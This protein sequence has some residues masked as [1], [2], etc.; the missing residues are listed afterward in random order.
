M[1]GAPEYAFSDAVTV[2]Q[3]RRLPESATLAGYSALIA[4]LEVKTPLI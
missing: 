2:F 1:A 3:E 4:A